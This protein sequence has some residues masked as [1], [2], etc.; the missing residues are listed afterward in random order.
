MFPTGFS[1]MIKINVA[2][3]RDD[4]QGPMQVVSGP[5]GRRKIHFEAPP[6]AML[7]KAI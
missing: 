1:G 2:Q 5:V 6:A 7:E 4:K 3:W